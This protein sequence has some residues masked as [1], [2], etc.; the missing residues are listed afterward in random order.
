MLNIFPYWALAVF[1]SLVKHQ[2]FQEC[3]WHVVKWNKETWHLILLLFY[4][5][6]NHDFCL[7]SFFLH[8]LCNFKQDL[9]VIHQISLYKE[10][11]NICTFMFPTGNNRYKEI[12]LEAFPSFPQEY[13][14][15][16]RGRG[17]FHCMESKKFDTLTSLLLEFGWVSEKADFS[18]KHIWVCMWKSTLNHKLT[19]YI[20]WW[21]KKRIRSK[22]WNTA[23]RVLKMNELPYRKAIIGILVSIF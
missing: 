7:L 4:N 1:T 6:C 20:D 17:I 19:T 16:E 14:D 10:H 8:V 21:E 5:C 22:S 9:I 13:A 15:M 18:G 23:N 2:W 3:F 12:P 11:L